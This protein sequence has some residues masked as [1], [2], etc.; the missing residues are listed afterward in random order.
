[1]ATPSEGKGRYW[2]GG[3]K[4]VVA[5]TGIGMVNATETTAAALDRFSDV[6][7]FSTPATSFRRRGRGYGTG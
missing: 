2:Q 7:H 6:A 4:V 1:M 5:M 3:K